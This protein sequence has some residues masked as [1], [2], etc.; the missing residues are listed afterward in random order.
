MAK[1]VNYPVSF[2]TGIPN[3]NIPLYQIEAEGMTLP[4][5]L[6][7]HAGGFRTNEKSTGV[8]LGWSLSTDLQI[9]RSINGIDDFSA[10]G[11]ISN[12][13]MKVYYETNG[14]TADQ[15]AYP[16]NN[17]D[18]LAPYDVAAGNKDGMPDKFYYK[19]LNKSGSFYFQKTT[20]GSG[21]TIVPVPYDNISIQYVNGAFTITDTDGTA[22]YYG[23]PGTPGQVP[24]LLANKEFSPASIPV[25]TAWKCI[26]IEN[27]HKTETI[28][29]TYAEKSLVRNSGNAESIEYYSNES[30]C[31]LNL[32]YT[33]E[34]YG[35]TN[36][37]TYEGLTG[38]KPFYYLSSPKYTENFSDQAS[39]FHWPYVNTSGQVQDKQFTV[40]QPGNGYGTDIYG[41]SLARIDFSGG[42]VTFTGTD[43]ITEIKVL[44]TANS[45]V[46]SFA[47][48]QSF[49]APFNLAA[50]K[51]ANGDAFQGTMYLDSIQLK[52]NDA[53]VYE[54]YKFMYNSKYCFGSHLKGKDAWGYVNNYTR[55]RAQAGTVAVVPEQNIVQRFYRDITGGCTNFLAAVS[56]RIGDYF[57]YEVTSDWGAQ[58]GVLN[59]IVYPT[60]GYVDFD[61]ESNMF[62]E[63]PS[64]NLQ[65]VRMSGGLRIR[66]ISYYDG[67]SFQPVSQKYYRY[68][69][70]ENGLGKVIHAPVRNYNMGRVEYDGYSYNQTIA[71]LTGPGTAN[72]GHDFEPVPIGCSNKS[73]LYY[74]F[75]EKKR[76]YLPAS[77]S[78]YTFPNGAPVYYTKVTEYNQDF[79]INTGK[80]VYTFY[81]ADA[82]GQYVYSISKKDK[83]PGT[84]VDVLNTD[85]LMGE[86]KSEE[87]YK[88]ENGK[89]TLIHGKYTAFQKYLKAAQIRVVYSYF[90]TIYRISAG[91]YS[92]GQASL[93]NRNVSFAPAAVYDEQ[94][95]IMGQYGIQV[96][97]LLL[98]SQTEKWFDNND[99]ITQKTTY[100]YDNSEYIQPSRIV[101]ESSRGYDITKSLKYTYDFPGDN[102]CVQM[103][104]VNIISPVVEEITS[105]GLG[106]ISRSRTNFG[107][108]TQGAGFFAPLSLQQSVNGKPLE[109]TMTFDQYDEHANILQTTGRDGLIKSYIWGYNYKY[110]VAEIVGS[111]YPNSAGVVN[112][113]ALQ[114]IT[115]DASLRTALAPLRTGIPTAMTTLFTY[116]PMV[117]ITGKTA[118]NG[119]TV[120]YEYDTYNRLTATR[121][122]SNILS[123]N[124][125]VMAGTG[126]GTANA[127]NLYYTNVPVMRTFTRVCSDQV[128]RPYNYIIP[129]GTYTNAGKSI[130]NSTAENT[131]EIDGPLYVGSVD[132]S[133]TTVL[134]TLNMN[135]DLTLF[136]VPADGVYLDFIQDNAVVATKKF[137]V[138][139]TNQTELYLKPGTYR[140]SMRLNTNFTGAALRYSVSP[141]A[142]VGF[143]VKPGDAVNLAAG[144][145]YSFTVSNWL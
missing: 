104:G 114:S 17:L 99:S 108:I 88:F 142:G 6:D 102:I 77:A 120:T 105:S 76:T 123:K 9:T 90:N 45:V 136:P 83:I 109:T 64:E 5:G 110:P 75:K 93:Y 91:N 122:N 19:L 126:T 67:K 69:E 103:K 115:N 44:N 54:R 31:N 73:C 79:G 40:N 138:R 144:V 12:P 141:S 97:K 1:M 94:D 28:N 63:A 24:Y 41:L 55:E 27:A 127:S 10:G 137:P 132:C 25:F 53:V 35:T 113:V 129:G 48:Y 2:N 34:S 21:F 20:S 139:N 50:A 86:Q 32:Y 82:F 58:T 4:V 38:T 106:E 62:N 111:T 74:R 128:K 116:K 29:F 65:A 7:Y 37:T 46:K 72:A 47:F 117:G 3:I 30:P 92:G 18:G 57:N 118:P 8:G 131:I 14:S 33:S 23:T 51:I 96:A 59:R 98:S 56:F 78:N 85:G 84:N 36:T 125:Y 81:E 52:G 112:V 134:V 13:D 42:A 15:Y 71:Y 39:V 101:T 70:M 26:R 124:E 61:Y 49:I 89:Y 68:G 95:F 145:S 60:G 43:Q 140:V 11:Y 66:S 121:E 22:Y 16:L 133:G 143:S 119:R 100:Y 107:R 135:M 80:K 130:P 87:D